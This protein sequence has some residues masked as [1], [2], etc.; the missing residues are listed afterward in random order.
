LL[1]V[2]GIIGENKFNVKGFVKEFEN[3]FF[4]LILAS[5]LLYFEHDK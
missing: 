1:F 3:F 5:F 4:F 2:D